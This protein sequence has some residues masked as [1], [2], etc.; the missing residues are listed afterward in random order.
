M[1]SKSVV[2]KPFDVKDPQDYMLLLYYSVVTSRVLTSKQNKKQFKYGDP[3]T[4]HERCNMV[5]CSVTVVSL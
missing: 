2:L 5:K 1:S 3:P 4:L